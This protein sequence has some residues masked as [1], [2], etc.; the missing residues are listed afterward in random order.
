MSEDLAVKAAGMLWEVDED[1]LFNTL[2]SRGYMEDIIRAVYAEQT[3][4]LE[5]LRVATAKCLELAI[6]G[7]IFG[8][9]R[10]QEN[11]VLRSQ[12]A[13]LQQQ[14]E[15]LT[16]DA[17]RLDWLADKDNPVAQVLLPTECVEANVHS[18]RAAIDAA[19]GR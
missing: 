1:G 19:R 9:D 12:V 16:E 5:R 17:E 2:L 13:E 4:E 14:V 8:G 7:T 3:A 11:A 6:S 15:R 10:M 18:L